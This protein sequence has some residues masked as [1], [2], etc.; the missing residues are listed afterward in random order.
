MLLSEITFSVAGGELVKDDGFVLRTHNSD[1]AA[2]MAIGDEGVFLLDIDQSGQGYWSV[3]VGFFPIL[4]GS[5]V[6]PESAKHMPG[7]EGRSTMTKSDFLSLLK[8]IGRQ[9]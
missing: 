3:N 5:V 9:R 1:A 6:I 8:G 7:I 4:K 2:K